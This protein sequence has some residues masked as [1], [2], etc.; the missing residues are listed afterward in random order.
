KP[1]A[2]KGLECLPMVLMDCQVMRG[3]HGT[4]AMEVI[5]HFLDEV[6]FV[7]GVACV[8]SHPHTMGRDFGWKELQRQEKS[9]K[10]NL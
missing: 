8:N 6:R 5:G 1:D 9:D 4:D 7:R 3:G 2:A 10:M